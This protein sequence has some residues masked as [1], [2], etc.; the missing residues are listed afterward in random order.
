M[1]AFVPLSN[2]ENI[3]MI[4]AP[5]HTRSR[6]RLTGIAIG[7]GVCAIVIVALNGR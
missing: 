6:A 4:E 7:R 1:A 3:Y 2:M 5:S